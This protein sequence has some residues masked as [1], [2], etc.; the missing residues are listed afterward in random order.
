MPQSNSTTCGTESSLDSN[1]GS[2]SH[3][4]GRGETGMGADEF[5]VMAPLVVPSGD[6]LDPSAA[7]LQKIAGL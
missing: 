1:G 5:G 2:V 3:S 6:S 7:E 4:K